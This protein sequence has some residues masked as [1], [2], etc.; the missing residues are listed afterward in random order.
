MRS[1]DRSRDQMLPGIPG[2]PA[3]AGGGVWF[4]VERSIPI[5][6]TG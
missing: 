3:G 5:T 1:S 6:L 2:T 4:A